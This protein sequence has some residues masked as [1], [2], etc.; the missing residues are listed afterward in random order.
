MPVSSF[1]C[2]Y[3]LAPSRELGVS[4]PRFPELV[5]GI[6]RKILGRTI[7]WDEPYYTYVDYSE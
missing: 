6:V 5:G 7:G 2:V 1:T 4:R 3:V